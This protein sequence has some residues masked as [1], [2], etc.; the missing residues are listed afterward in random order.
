MTVHHQLSL[1]FAL[2]LGL[3]LLSYF[4]KLVS[5]V[6]VVGLNCAALPHAP[7]CVDQVIQA[8]VSLGLPIN[9]F[10]ILGVLLF[11]LLAVEQS[12][13]VLLQSQLAGCDVAMDDFLSI[14]TT[15][16]SG[17]KLKALEYSSKA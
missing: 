4:Q 1:P 17:S 5:E 15:T 11:G 8:E 13:V 10:Y 12:Q 2:V 14:S 16:L 3:G 6:L 7:S 9:S